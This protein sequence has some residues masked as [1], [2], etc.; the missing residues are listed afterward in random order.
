MGEPPEDRRAAQGRRLRARDGLED[1]QIGTIERGAEGWGWTGR[2]ADW[3]YRE[4]G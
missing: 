2:L 1:W 3:Y 4:G